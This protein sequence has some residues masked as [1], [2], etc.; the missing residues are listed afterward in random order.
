MFPCF[1]KER[2]EFK[3]KAVRY[4]MVRGRSVEGVWSP[5]SLKVGDWWRKG[6]G[7]AHAFN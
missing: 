5:H 3:G 6:V 2:R 7:E 1:R 4:G